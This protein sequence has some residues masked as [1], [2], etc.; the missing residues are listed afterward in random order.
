MVEPNSGATP[1]H[2]GIAAPP[3]PPPPPPRVA[4]PPMLQIMLVV[5]TAQ[6]M[7]SHADLAFDSAMSHIL[8]LLPPPAAA[9]SRPGSARLSTAAAGAGAGAAE[10]L[11]PPPYE[12]AL[13]TYHAG[14][15]PPIRTFPWTRHVA[16]LRRHF[17][18]LH[19]RQDVLRNTAIDAVRA[20]HAFAMQRRH[21]LR[22][23]AA[24]MHRRRPLGDAAAPPAAET[25]SGTAAFTTQ[26]FLLPATPAYP[27]A[28]LP[29]PVLGTS[30]AP[31]PLAM[32]LESLVGP[33]AK[34]R[35]RLRIVVP[36]ALA[37][38]DDR[39]LTPAVRQQLE[40]TSTMP[41][42]P[43]Q[44]PVDDDDG[45]DAT[46]K[47]AIMADA[48]PT[49]DALD[50]A[51]AALPATTGAA[52]APPSADATAVAP[53][54]RL[55]VDLPAAG[56]MSDASLLPHGDSPIIKRPKLEPEPGAA[57]GTAGPTALT[58]A[59]A[60]TATPTPASAVV[61]PSPASSGSAV[62]APPSAS[63]PPTA[64]PLSATAP[65]TT[66]AAT[67]TDAR[68][69]TPSAVLAAVAPTP[70]AATA[71]AAGT[72]SAPLAV[73]ATA[74]AAAVA[75]AGTPSAVSV[76]T[77]AS[78]PAAAG[79]PTVA[80]RKQLVWTGQLE[81]SQQQCALD[82]FLIPQPWANR[83]DVLGLPL[84]PRKWVM[85]AA[86]RVP[87]DALLGLA[88]NHKLP[89]I[90]L[91]AGD[92]AAA[93]KSTPTPAAATPAGAA[94]GAKPSQ[95]LYESMLRFLAVRKVVAICQFSEATPEQLSEAQLPAQDDAGQPIVRGI[96]I[97]QTKERMLAFVFV[98]ASLSLIPGF[99]KPVPLAAKA[100]PAS[101]V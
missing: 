21:T 7:A 70:V 96:A 84:W 68:L 25:A 35:L 66:T 69:A 30:A 9:A 48:L 6:K 62:A 76:G 40:L 8:P 60:S 34:D 56:P 3:P 37:D 74:A 10:A 50:A 51:P 55:P 63:D 99:N 1:S 38:I 19:F 18:T 85:T 41:W 78:T 92:A 16:I 98:K 71:A 32:T 15:Q 23:A 17:Q 24:V 5:D 90:A 29:L 83:T 26:V 54:K 72:P 58:P 97:A 75:A 13:V 87:H 79:T 33:W 64:A 39:V 14:A 86:L 31:S 4:S 12:L 81:V 89:V 82:A 52:P 73:S 59:P 49:A 57:A 80:R 2:S 20:A 53:M 27:T 95:S 42:P 28:S 94:A 43:R 44:E 67:V 91:A 65:A 61:A 22:R 88:Q 93:A 100:P 77:P 46:K 11:Q 47:E 101:T 45:D 36:P